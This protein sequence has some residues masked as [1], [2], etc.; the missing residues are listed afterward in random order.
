MKDT[1]KRIPMNI[2]FPSQEEKDAAIEK[3]RERRK[4]V[5]LLVQEFF[6]RLPSK[7]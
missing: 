3:A 2:S 1:R 4:T 6:R 7:K 5:S